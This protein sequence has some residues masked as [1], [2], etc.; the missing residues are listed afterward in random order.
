MAPRQGLDEVGGEGIAK[1][2]R[3]AAPGRDGP[4]RMAGDSAAIAWRLMMDNRFDSKA[5]LE[6]L[7]KDL[8][9]F[10]EFGD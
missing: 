5:V 10:I 7:L 3:S 1:G 2:P 9:E 8:S 6:C 4:A